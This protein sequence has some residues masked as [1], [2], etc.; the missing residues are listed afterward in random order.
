MFLIVYNYISSN[1]NVFSVSEIRIC[2]LFNGNKVKVQT[3]PTVFV[4]SNLIIF[5]KGVGPNPHA[6]LP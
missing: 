1:N 4:F 6:S 3:P 2:K 5:R